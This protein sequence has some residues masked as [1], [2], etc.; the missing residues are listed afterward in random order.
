MPDTLGEVLLFAAAAALTPTAILAGLLLLLTPRPRGNGGAYLVG[1]MAGLFVSAV[2]L[3]R[4]GSDPALERAVSEDPILRP[5]IVFLAGLAMIVAG[6][7][8]LRAGQSSP[9]EPGWL[10]RVD[11]FSPGLSFGLGFFLGALSPKLLLLTGATVVTL[12]SFSDSRLGR[13]LGLVVYVFVA[14][15]PILIPVGIVLR[16]SDSARPRLTSWKAWLVANQSR[17]LGGGSI[18]IG[19]L[20]VASAAAAYQGPA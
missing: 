20:L 5:G 3:L 15:I 17:L 13:L 4:V 9:Q 14:S 1:W 18:L 6:I 12:V 19:L 2:I 8:G 11:S 7:L 16:D 10:R